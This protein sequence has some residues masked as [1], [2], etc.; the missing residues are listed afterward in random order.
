MEADRSTGDGMML[1]STR[2]A[3]PLV[4][5]LS[6]HERA[7]DKRKVNATREGAGATAPA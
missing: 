5:S 2:S 1:L 3:T 4:V 7:V 6:N